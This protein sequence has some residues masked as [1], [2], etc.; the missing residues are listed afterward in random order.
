[1]GLGVLA[2][3][4][5]TEQSNSNPL[6]VNFAQSAAGL[7]LVAGA[8]QLPAHCSSHL[9]T[10]ARMTFASMEVLCR[11]LSCSTG[12]ERPRA[13]KLQGGCPWFRSSA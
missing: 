6:L 2:M 5:F 7:G 1:M 10:L 12:E 4:V 13:T 11:D 3:E 9:N 8:R